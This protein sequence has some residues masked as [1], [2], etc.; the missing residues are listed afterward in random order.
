MQ[1]K[2]LAHLIFLLVGYACAEASDGSRN[3][4]QETQ[5]VKERLSTK[6]TD[7]QRVD[8]CK[9]PLARRNPSR[10]RPTD[11]SPSLQQTDDPDLNNRTK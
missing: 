8:D 11:C 10:P 7:P 3:S 6:A 4:P 2:I 9:V 1:P 5:T